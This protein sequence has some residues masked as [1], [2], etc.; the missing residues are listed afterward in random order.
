MRHW[1]GHFCLALLKRHFRTHLTNIFLCIDKTMIFFKMFCS[2]SESKL[3]TNHLSF[4]CHLVLS[5]V[6]SAVSFK[7]YIVD[8]TS[9]TKLFLRL[10]FRKSSVKKL[11]PTIAQ[12]FIRENGATVASAGMQ[13]IISR[14]VKYS[15]APRLLKPPLAAVTCLWIIYT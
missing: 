6:S 9:W 3:Y 12:N 7:F 10:G 4:V 13:V 15:K 5:L 14:K 8:F 1:K 11:K 2:K